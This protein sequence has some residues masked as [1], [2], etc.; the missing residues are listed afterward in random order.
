M[1]PITI[2][3]IGVIVL[4]VLIALRVPVGVS[5]IGVSLVGIYLVAGENAVWSVSG[6]IPYTW[7]ATWTFSSIPMFLLMGYICYHS[8]LTPGLFECA[9][10]WLSGVPGGLAIASVLGCAGFSSL[11]GSS[12][13]T[14]AAMG[15]IAIPEMM[16]HGYS[17]ALATGTLAASGTLGAL[18]PPSTLLLIYAI[19]AQQPVPP[20]FMGGVGAG[21]V[22]AASFIAV[23]YV[24]VRLNPKLA[25]M[26]EERPSWGERFAALGTIWPVIALVGVVFGGM[27]KGYF[28]ASEAG[29]IGAISSLLIAATKR[30]LTWQRLKGAVLETI[31]ATAS[32]FIIGCG[33]V[34]LTAFLAYSGAGPYLAKTMLALG[35]SP[36]EIIIMITIIY[37][38][39]GMFLEP[40]GVL[41]LTM[42]IMLPM[43]KDAGINMVWFGVYIVKQLENSM[44]APPVG[45]NIFVIKNVVGDLIPT[46]TIYRG[47][48]WFLVADFVVTA[49]LIMFPG[50]I[51]FLPS[52]L[53]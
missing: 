2:G 37:F 49:L 5:M 45:M 22:T 42:P 47:I 4:I 17:P 41:L 29:A 23:I 13:V 26:V 52:L 48:L 32:L 16:K 31:V 36:L 24:R 14:A 46:A 35:E 6:V 33:A 3:I 43:A 11:T 21:L 15:R 1:D 50:I 40:I 44:I 8:G 18:F 27:A 10:L 25:P 12:L 34:M 53:R 20:L 39:L 28:T 19:I 30:L 9:R 38:V 51:L 7:A